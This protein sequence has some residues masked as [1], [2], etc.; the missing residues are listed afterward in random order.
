MAT[1]VCATQLKPA[2]AHHRFLPGAPRQ[3]V[4]R[5]PHSIAEDGN[6]ADSHDRQGKSMRVN[7][8]LVGCIPVQCIY[9]SGC[10]GKSLPTGTDEPPGRTSASMGDR[11]WRRNSVHRP[12]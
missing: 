6:V 5:E 2:N 11:R 8:C 4:D 3:P 7:G 1:V 12:R 9:G 10:H